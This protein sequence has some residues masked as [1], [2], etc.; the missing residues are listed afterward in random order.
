VTHRKKIRFEGH[1][2]KSCQ[3][4]V[5]LILMMFILG[6]ATAAYILKTL[7]TS[8]LQ[9]E[10]ND[11]TYQALKEAK[12]AL[13]AWAV[14]HPKIPGL[15]PY[16]DR[17][18]D[19]GRYDGFS[20]CPGDATAHKHLIGRLPWKG[21]DYNHCA[22]LLDGL[23]KRFVDGDNEPLW[24][25]VSRNLVHI[26]EPTEDPIVNPG[27]ISTTARWLKVLDRHG[28]LI[29]DRVAVVIISPGVALAGQNRSGS[30]PNPDKYLDGMKIGANSYSN[31]DYD[32]DDEDFVMGEDSRYVSDLDTSIQKPYYFNDKLIYITIDEL[33]HALE[34]RAL[35]EARQ[36]LTNYYLASDASTDNRFYP[37]AATLGDVGNMCRE[38]KLSGFL[39]IYLH[40]AS[41][42]CTSSQSCTVGFPAT[43]VAFSASLPFDYS[44]H[45]GACTHEGN[46]CSCSGPGSCSRS[47]PSKKFTCI[48]NGA[49]TSSGAGSDGSFTFTYTPS[50]PDVT[51][52]SGAC[53][54][55]S[56]SVIC[57]GF[58]DFGSPRSNCSHPKPGLAEFP[59]WF[60]VNLWQHYIY[61]LIS[62]DCSYAVKGCKSP[63]LTVGTRSDVHAAVIGAG[64]ALPE[65]LAKGSLQVRPSNNLNDYL[66]SIE[67]TNNDS[68]Y[69]SAGIPR[70]VTYNDQV[71]TVAP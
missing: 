35:Q 57:S 6:L 53:S 14:A 4:G 71:I 2:L 43:K 46:V 16:P 52:V 7:N 24:Y 20:D 44:S 22:Y 27:I 8:N 59:E 18:T 17:N 70:N 23:G 67:N 25:A 49:C 38:S 51:E 1:T 47:S 11:K 61:Y 19:P 33:M 34:K 37:Y 40:T 69:D 9:F 29:S 10:Q 39:P 21:G 60:T 64:V 62:S 42:Y 32:Q 26:Y 41:A 48:A 66:D 45:T 65:T 36:Q 15:M 63:S 58:G 5:V 56:G 3:K 68:V 55:S 13:I 54:G 28:N 50:I 31:A 30:A 12:T